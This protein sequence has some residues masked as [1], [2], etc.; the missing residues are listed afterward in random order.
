MD[1]EL[2][3]LHVLRHATKPVL[4]IQVVQQILAVVLLWV[5]VRA[6]IQLLVTVVRH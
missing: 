5:A 2:V 1:V 4:V 6:D 3:N